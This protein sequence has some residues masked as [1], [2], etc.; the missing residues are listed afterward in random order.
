MVDENGRGTVRLTETCDLEG[1]G[2]AM[3]VTNIR[4]EEGTSKHGMVTAMMNTLLGDT[5]FFGRVLV[6][7]Y[8]SL[9]LALEVDSAC[10][11]CLYNGH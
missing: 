10:L 4:A 7:S 3:V 8:S 5:D 1:Q 9:W 2:H 11:L 6:S